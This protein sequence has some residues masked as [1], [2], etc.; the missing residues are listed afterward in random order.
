MAQRYW[1]KYIDKDTGEWTKILPPGEDLAA[2][3]SG[4]GRDALT[5]PKMW[6][7]YSVITQPDSDLERLG[8]ASTR[9][10]AEHAALTLFGVHQQSQRTLMHQHDAGLGAALRTLRR[11]DKSSGEAVDRRVEALVT[12]TSV[13]TMTYRLRGLVIQ[14]RGID[15][16]LDYNR[17]VNEIERWHWPAGRQSVR[18][19][20]AQGY[21]RWEKPTELGDS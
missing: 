11:H 1:N 21:Q 19:G 16:P 2:L 9:Q 4:L 7:F 20:W 17:L 18:K 14:L 13:A 15:Q 3:R 6:Q 5:V 12:S 10:E 8:V